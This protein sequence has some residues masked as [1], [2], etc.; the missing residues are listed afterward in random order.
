MSAA[1]GEA[2]SGERGCLGGGP[3]RCDEFVEKYSDDKELEQAMLEYSFP[4]M[5]E[6][7]KLL[8]GGPEAPLDVRPG[9]PILWAALLASSVFRQWAYTVLSQLYALSPSDYGDFVSLRSAT[10][11]DG[12][13]YAD[14][15]YA[16]TIAAVSSMGVSGACATLFGARRT[17]AAGLVFQVAGCAT[18][19]TAY[20]AWQLALGT[21]VQAAGYGIFLTPACS[22]GSTRRVSGSH[23]ASSCVI[24]LESARCTRSKEVPPERSS[25]V[26]QRAHLEVEVSKRFVLS[27]TCDVISRLHR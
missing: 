17:A 22:P 7:A 18:C 13:E 23:L 5:P 10:G 16:Y 14:I 11:L 8:F 21:V 1:A 26:G 9:A 24:S 6:Q 15:V 27:V 2:G 3:L 25:R 20:G 19:A 4:E 12:D